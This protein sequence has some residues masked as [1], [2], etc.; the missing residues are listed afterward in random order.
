MM[1]A[2][3]I[4]FNSKCHTLIKCDLRF[5]GKKNMQNKN[6]MTIDN[7]NLPTEENESQ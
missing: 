3:G 6:K 7:D 1:L 2:V 5:Q 4:G